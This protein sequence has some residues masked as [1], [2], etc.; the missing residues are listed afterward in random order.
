MAHAIWEFFFKYPPVVFEKGRLVFSSPLPLMLL[1]LAVVAAGVAT[2]SYFI[3]PAGS[4][5]RIASRLL[6]LALRFSRCW[7]LSC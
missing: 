3:G 2:W 7:S 5:R 6:I 1:L 4:R